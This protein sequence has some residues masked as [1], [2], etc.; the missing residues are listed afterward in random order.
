MHN[1]GVLLVVPEFLCQSTTSG[2]SFPR[3]CSCL[4]LPSQSK[5][6]SPAQKE[7]AAPLLKSKWGMDDSSS[8]DEQEGLGKAEGRRRGEAGRSERGG[9]AERERQIEKQVCAE[10]VRRRDG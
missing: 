6:I 9:D 2:L 7:A 3:G 10:G 5:L 4:Y 1:G 8:E